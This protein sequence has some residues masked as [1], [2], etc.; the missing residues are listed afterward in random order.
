[1]LKLK[2][3]NIRRKVRKLL[4]KKPMEVLQIK[5]VKSVVILNNPDSNLNS[6]NFK[7]LQ[8]SLGLNNNQFGILTFTQKKDQYNELKG[9]VATK[10]VFSIFGNVKDP[11]ILEFLN[12]QYDLLI[13]F[14]NLSNVYEKYF[15]LLIK[16]DFRVGYINDEELYDLMINVPFGDI[17]SFIDEMTKYLKIIGS[18]N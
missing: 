10:K 9:I 2:K 6:E 12:N 14:T 11:E 5:P 17:K 7:Y 4:A 1:L 3:N 8:K 13:D 16:S 15:S 18:I